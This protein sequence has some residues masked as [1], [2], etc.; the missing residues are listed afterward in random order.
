ML[1]EIVGRGSLKDYCPISIVKEEADWEYTSGVLAQEV[2]TLYLNNTLELNKNTILINC[3]W[4]QYTI[5]S[6]LFIIYNILYIV[7]T[8]L[9]IEYCAQYILLYKINCVLQTIYYI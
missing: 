4:I 8:L 9:Y 7:Y 1:N 5:Y 2:Y 3:I 6:I